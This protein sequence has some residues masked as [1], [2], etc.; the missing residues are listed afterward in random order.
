MT[1]FH[2][3]RFV[4]SWVFQFGSRFTIHTQ[5]NFRLQRR[6]QCVGWNGFLSR[7][8]CP[9]AWRKFVF[10][11]MIFAFFLVSKPLIVNPIPHLSHTARAFFAIFC[12]FVPQRGHPFFAICKIANRLFFHFHNCSKLGFCTLPF[13]DFSTRAYIKKKK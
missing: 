4:Q 7:F 11:S 3:S 13:S 1:L 8:R 2:I 9:R 12:N 10:L 6:P 5:R